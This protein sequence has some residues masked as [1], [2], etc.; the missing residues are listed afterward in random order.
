MAR[1]PVLYGERNMMAPSETE[2]SATSLSRLTDGL[3]LIV[4][5]ALDKSG[6]MLYSND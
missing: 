4:C 1:Q 2:F 5:A 6:L 3:A